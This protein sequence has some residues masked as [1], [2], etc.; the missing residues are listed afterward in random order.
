MTIEAVVP[1]GGHSEYGDKANTDASATDNEALKLE[2]PW[3]GSG[4][5]A[6][7]KCSST[8]K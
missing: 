5:R 4:G 8:E 1:R 3:T 7:G 6:V 2:V